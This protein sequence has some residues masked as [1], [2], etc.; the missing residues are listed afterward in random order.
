M[1]KIRNTPHPVRDQ[2]AELLSQDLPRDE[3]MKRM[4]ISADSY[5]MHL[6]RVRRDLGWQAI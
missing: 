6:R 5:K 3:I 4:G 1:G 2:F